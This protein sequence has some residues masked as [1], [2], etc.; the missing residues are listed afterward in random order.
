VV[1]FSGC[2][3]DGAEC[4]NKEPSR[5]ETR[6]ERGTPCGTRVREAK[7]AAHDSPNGERRALAIDVDR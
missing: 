6:R 1:L 5:R 2:P 3:N 7:I 4:G